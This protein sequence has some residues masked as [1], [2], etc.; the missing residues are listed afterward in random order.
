MPRAGTKAATTIRA[1]K[2]VVEVPGG[3]VVRPGNSQAVDH[4]RAAPE[5]VKQGAPAEAEKQAT[6]PASPAAPRRF[7]IKKR[8]ANVT[9]NG[10]PDWA[11][12]EGGRQIDT[13][14]RRK[15]AQA[16]VQDNGELDAGRPSGGDGQA[17]GIKHPR[18][19]MGS[20][21]LAAVS[22]YLGG[23]DP[24]WIAEFSVR[25]QTSKIG[26]DG[27]PLII[28]R[29]P[30]IPGIGY[31]FRAGGTQDLQ[32]LAEL[33][34]A[35]GYLEPGAV[36]A[37][38]KEAGE[39]AKRLIQDA[40]NR[41]ELQTV[42]D[43]QAE[44]DASEEAE[45]QAWYEEVNAEAAADLEAERQAIMAELEIQPDDVH[46]MNDVSWD[47]PVGTDR[48]AAMRALGFTEQE[49]ADESGR[50]E[51]GA[52]NAKASGSVPARPGEDD[53]PAENRAAAP[54]NRGQEEDADQVAGA[55]ARSAK[56][57][58]SRPDDVLTPQTPADLEAKA[59]R[60]GRADKL[61]QRACGKLRE[62]R[63]QV[64]RTEGCRL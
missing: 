27:R 54:R 35:E 30:L 18:T 42:D 19:I 2:E 14:E 17:G 11:V 12:Y 3:R 15:D 33:A 8:P 63:R 10:K 4:L 13:F 36:K 44:R 7:T 41:R 32:E 40:L 5:L 52:G 55:D 45:R 28:W 34:E 60:E 1:G 46:A 43:V 20:R 59:E 24:A 22:R 16:W 47:T 48:A 21:W 53:A 61:D 56:S 57:P 26:K 58:T 31:L 9:G 49:I 64:P 38:Y 39:R 50:E 37:D 23:L 25:V 29:N 62:R 51:E 6:L